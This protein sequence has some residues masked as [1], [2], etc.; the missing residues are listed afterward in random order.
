MIKGTKG[1]TWLSRGLSAWKILNTVSQNRQKLTHVLYV[2]SFGD[3][4]N[5][6]CNS[7]CIDDYGMISALDFLQVKSLHS[8]RA[9]DMAKNMVLN[10]MF[11][12]EGVFSWV[13]VG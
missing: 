8:A 6:E 3:S 12:I 9:Q 1:Y 2:F 7:S 13:I 10:C 11:R 5:W 4:S